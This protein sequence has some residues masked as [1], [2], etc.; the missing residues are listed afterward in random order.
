[1]LFNVIMDSKKKIQLWIF[2]FKDNSIFLG[3][4]FAIMYWAWEHCTLQCSVQLHILQETIEESMNISLQ[5]SVYRKEKHFIALLKWV[6]LHSS[7]QFY[8]KAED[9]T[10]SQKYYCNS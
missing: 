2:C 1:M 5:W 10:S 7:E 9:H 4:D 6:K 3:C 8:T